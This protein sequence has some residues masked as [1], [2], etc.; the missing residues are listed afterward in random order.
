MKEEKNKLIKDSDR[1]FTKKSAE[2]VS[3]STPVSKLSMTSRS[4]FPRRNTV[5]TGK[6]SVANTPA[7][8]GLK[9]DK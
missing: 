6:S 8:V 9:S 4:S 5:Q 7:R 2:P 1:E 3:A